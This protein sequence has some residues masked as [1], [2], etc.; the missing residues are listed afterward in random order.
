MT[1]II[2]LDKNNGYQFGGKRQSADREVR[3]RILKLADVIRCDEYT[4]AQ[5]DEADRG[6]LYVGS[7]YLNTINGTCF[8]EK[9]DI[10]E[11]KHYKLVVFWWN[12]GYPSTK[13]FTIPDGFRL[14]SKEN[15]Q[16]YSH[17]RITMEVFIR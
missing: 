12:R 2:C 15:F 6:K 3:G 5:F 9:G 14:V 10:S 7:D 16:G 17:D 8:V 13:K 4:A 11:L 1:V